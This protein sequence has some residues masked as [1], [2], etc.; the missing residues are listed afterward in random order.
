MIIEFNLLV[1]LLVQMPLSFYML[2]RLCYLLFC[3]LECFLNLFKKCGVF[4][5]AKWLTRIQRVFYLYLFV[6]R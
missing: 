2:Y 6:Y 3:F 1:I 5:N 4:K